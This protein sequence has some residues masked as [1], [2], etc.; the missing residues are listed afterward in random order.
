MG[1]GGRFGL[2]GLAAR[3]GR[4]ADRQPVAWPALL[5]AWA[6]IMGQ[7]WPTRPVLPFIIL[8]FYNF[9]YK[10]LFCI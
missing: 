6:A 7:K 2:P 8:F 10:T 3:L 5:A 1:D 9:Q 4:R